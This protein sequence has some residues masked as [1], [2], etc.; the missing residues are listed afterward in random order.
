[1]NWKH[2]K[3]ILI[4]KQEIYFL[5]KN[6]QQNLSDMTFLKNMNFFNININIR[7]CLEHK[8]LILIKKILLFNFVLLLLTL[9]LAGKERI[10]FDS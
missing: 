5:S 2:I 10:I 1:M 4:N 8:I 6:N 3:Y 9:N 7:H